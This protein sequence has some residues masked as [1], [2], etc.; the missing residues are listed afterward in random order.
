MAKILLPFVDDYGNE[1]IPKDLLYTS[2][3]ARYY[4]YKGAL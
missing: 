2:Y 1:Y 4:F 3:M